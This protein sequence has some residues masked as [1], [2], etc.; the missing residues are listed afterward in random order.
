M[1]ISKLL[2]IWLVETEGVVEVRSKTIFQKKS[3]TKKSFDRWSR[4]SHEETHNGGPFKYK[5]ENNI[6][7]LS[8]TSKECCI[9]KI[10][11]LLKT[12]YLVTLP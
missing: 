8:I 10:S 9:E 11:T 12:W 2:K 5:A 6:K 4:Y 7:L 1:E 3:Y